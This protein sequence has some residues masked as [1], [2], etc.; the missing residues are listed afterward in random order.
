L[1]EGTIMVFV[2]HKVELDD[3]CTR[4]ESLE[5]VNKVLRLDM[6]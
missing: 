1:F 6:E 3:L 5:G 4:L 2:N